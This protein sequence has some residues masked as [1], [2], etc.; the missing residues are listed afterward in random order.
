VQI[1]LAD[2]QAPVS[3]DIRE[4]AGD[5]YVILNETAKAKVL[6]HERNPERLWLDEINRRLEPLGFLS[7]RQA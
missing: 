3:D 6:Q 2:G 4:K 1:C 7:V 5:F